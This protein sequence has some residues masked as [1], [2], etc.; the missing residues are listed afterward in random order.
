M[1]QDAT[2]RPLQ[3]RK[4]RALLGILW[5]VRALFGGPVKAPVLWGPSSTK[6]KLKKVNDQRR[7][8]YSGF[9]YRKPITKLRSITWDMRSHSATCHPIQVYAPRGLTPSA[10]Q[11]GTWFTCPGEVKGWVDLGVSAQIRLG[12]RQE[13]KIY[14]RDVAEKYP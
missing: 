10:R 9:F 1:S 14:R 12:L 5:L 4:C 7:W 13:N 2:K 11:A 6:L 8:R 3:G